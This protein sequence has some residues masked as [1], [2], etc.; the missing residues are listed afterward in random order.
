L[1]QMDLLEKFFQPYGPVPWDDLINPMWAELVSHMEEA[2]LALDS[3]FMHQDQERLPLASLSGAKAIRVAPSE[4][5]FVRV[6]LSLP[7]D[8]ANTPTL[9][10]WRR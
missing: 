10:Q 3:G 6:P 9:G 7:P 4:H 2:W 5:D 8:S 1:E